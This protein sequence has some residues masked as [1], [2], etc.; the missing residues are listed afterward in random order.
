[1]KFVL[2]NIKDLK[3]TSP[4][5]CGAGG[6]LRLLLT[7]THPCSCLCPLSSGTAVSLSNNPQPRQ[8][9]ALTGPSS[10][11]HLFEAR[12]EHERAVDTVCRM[13]YPL[14]TIHRPAF[15]HLWLTGRDCLKH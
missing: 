9:S 6:S 8:A 14:L 13:G 3:M 1:M 5:L 11:G 15:H 7:I 4:A 10:C 2:I 12:V